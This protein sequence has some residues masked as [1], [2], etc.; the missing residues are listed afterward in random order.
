MALLSRNGKTSFFLDCKYLKK[1]IPN[2]TVVNLKVDE[3]ASKPP[4]TLLQ[5]LFYYLVHVEDGQQHGKHYEAHNRAHDEY[6]GGLK[7]GQRP[8]EA[9]L[10]VLVV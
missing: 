1:I 9:P 4:Y 2:G 3:A 8:F 7:Q 10:E 5:F 6:H